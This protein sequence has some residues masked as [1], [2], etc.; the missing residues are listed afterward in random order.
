M[1]APLDAVMAQALILCVHSFRGKKILLLLSP[2]F[3]IVL[4]LLEDLHGSGARLQEQ[5]RLQQPQHLVKVSLVIHR[6]R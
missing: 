5:W 3:A 6:R 4:I 2:R 1:D